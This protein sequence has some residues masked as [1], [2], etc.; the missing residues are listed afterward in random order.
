MH[1]RHF[2]G[3]ASAAILMTH[4]APLRAQ[5]HTVRFE[6]VVA[7]ARGAAAAPFDQP[8]LD[9]VP[10][11]ADL[12]Y[13]QFRGIRF[14][15]ERRLFAGTAF[16]V[17]LMPPG[18]LF[19]EGVR[20]DV[21]KDGETR[22]LD[23]NTNFYDFQDNYFDY[24]DGIPS[25]ETL[26]FTG[27]RFRHALNRPGVMD[28]LLVFQGAS[29]FRALAR[30]TLYG[31]SARGLAIGTGTSNP[32]EFPIF[33]RFWLNAPDPE[34]RSLTFLALLDGPSIAGAYEFVVT[35]GIETEMRVCSTLFPRRTIDDVGI[36]PL[37]SMYFFG[38]ERR[39]GWNDFRDAVHD[40]DG[41]EMVSGTGERLWRPLVNPDV[42]E[43][44]FF[45]DDGPQR[46]G[47]MQRPRDFTFYND[48]EARYELRPSAWVEPIGDWGPGN[49]MLVELPSPNEFADNIVAFWRPDTPL[50]QGNTYDFAYRLIWGTLPEVTDA[51]ARVQATRIGTSIMDEAEWTFALDFDRGELSADDVEFDL[52]ASAGTVRGVHLTD[53][54]EGSMLRAA[55]TFV[56]DPE[57]DA[58][59]FRGVLRGE[60]GRVSETWL[61][62]WR[63]RAHL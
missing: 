22:T 35:P 54:P 13:D 56:P 49:V 31:L 52:R 19:E 45:S 12:S 26:A 50:M 4:A 53:L 37:T 11:F 18:L 15:E 40:S 6:D 59:E 39:A 46:F 36:A 7:I 34:A 61:Y 17:E 33:T 62:R 21:T 32:E 38:P 28:E 58:V 42:V 48:S 23:F 55:F 44:S 41:L 30:D 10:P 3:T 63:T 16:E 27:V 1:R 2:L 8:T 51:L 25:A 14:R 20:I 29:Y 60:T 43:K 57:V 9:L 24:P 5:G 47:L